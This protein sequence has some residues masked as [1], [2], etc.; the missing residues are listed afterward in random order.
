MQGAG[1]ADANAARD[2][3]PRRAPGRA[4]GRA[5][6]LPFISYARMTSSRGVTALSTG[7]DAP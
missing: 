7:M 6:R 2:D 5:A 4:R 3:R 1:A